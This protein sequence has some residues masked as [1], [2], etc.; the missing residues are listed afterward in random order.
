MRLWRD[1]MELQDRLHHPY[2]FIFN[3]AELY[4]LMWS[5]VVLLRRVALNC[6]TQTGAKADIN[7]Q[8]QHQGLV[9][10]IGPNFILLP[11]LISNISIYICLNPSVI[12]HVLGCFLN[13]IIITYEQFHLSNTVGKKI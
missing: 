10:V 12:F 1:N 4:A 8:P 7:T 2:S 9:C 3:A 13:V 6:E 11:F 5:E